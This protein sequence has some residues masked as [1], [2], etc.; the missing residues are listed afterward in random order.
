MRPKNYMRPCGT[1]GFIILAQWWALPSVPLPT[2]TPDLKITVEQGPPRTHSN[3]LSFTHKV[4][5]RCLV[6]N[7]YIFYTNIYEIKPHIHRNVV[8][9]VGFRTGQSS[10]SHVHRCVY[11]W[12]RQPIDQS[13]NLLEAQGQGG[14][15]RL[16][17][18]LRV[19]SSASCHQ[20]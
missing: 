5:C 15:S 16:R 7:Q 2:H 1:A 13:L 14:S 3:F 18:C 10:H 17:Q 9:P 6:G 8:F 19:H 12:L 20:G 4:L 11:S